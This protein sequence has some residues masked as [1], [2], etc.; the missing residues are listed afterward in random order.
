[1]IAC[2]ERELRMRREF[3]PKRVERGQMTIEKA[4]HEIAAMLAVLELLRVQPGAPTGR[5]GATRFNYP[6][7][8]RLD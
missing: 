5:A 7:P 1:M 3:Y 6:S 4:E 2:V 8:P